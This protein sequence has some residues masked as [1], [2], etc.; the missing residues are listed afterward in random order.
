MMQDNGT[1][2][3]TVVKSDDVNLPD[4]EVSTKMPPV[5]EPKAEPTPGI[6]LIFKIGYK[7]E[8][9]QTLFHYGETYELRQDGLWYKCKQARLMCELDWG[10]SHLASVQDNV[11]FG[12]WQIRG[13]EL[14]DLLLAGAYYYVYQEGCWIAIPEMDAV[15]VTPRWEI[16]PNGGLWRYTDSGSKVFVEAEEPVEIRRCKTFNDVHFPQDAKIGDQTKVNGVEYSFTP[17]GW[18]ELNEE[19]ID[20]IQQGVQPDGGWPRD[21]QAP[22]HYPKQNFLTGDRL[23]A[24]PPLGSDELERQREI[25]TALG[26]AK[27]GSLPMLTQMLKSHVENLDLSPGQAERDPGIMALGALARVQEENQRKK[28]KR[29]IFWSVFILLLAAIGLGGYTWVAANIVKGHYTVPYECKVPFGDTELTGH[30]YRTYGY[31]ELFGYR[32]TGADSIVSERTEV[33]L[34]GENLT[35]LGFNGTKGKWW[36]MNY[37]K[38]EFGNSILK[39]TDKYWFVGDKKKT[40]LVTYDA[41]CN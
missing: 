25:R 5:K 13:A 34:P 41:F 17:D 15:A 14:G 22:R 29:L 8:V 7:P 36:R 23:Q 2:G 24:P 11:I 32:L 28:T 33:K 4:V 3:T 21:T 31:Q 10:V 39:P 35:I 18:L 16:D 9:G 38:G 37:A 6:R 40:A 30:R 12:T 1:E 20:R 26:R 19:L 27:N